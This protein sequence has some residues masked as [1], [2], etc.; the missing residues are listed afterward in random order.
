MRA[1]RPDRA[2][3]ALVAV[4][5]L[6]AGLAVAAPDGAIV[7]GDS[8]KLTRFE[9]AT[10]RESVTP[11]SARST[12]ALGFGG[13][14]VT[15]VEVVKRSTSAPDRYTVKLIRSGAPERALPPFS[16]SKGH[17]SGR[18]QPSP[19]ASLFAVHT[20]ESAG[21][22]EPYIDNVY[23]FDAQSRVK[24]RV[25]GFSDPVWAGSDRLVAVADDGLYA[26]P[27]A[28][29]RSAARIG[30]RRASPRRPALSPDG[31][32]IAF[33][34][35]DAVWR[36]GIDGSGLQRLTLPR[37]GQ[38]WPTWSPDGSRLVVVRREC[39]PVGGASPNP[40]LVIVSGSKADQDIERLPLVM[41]Q[42]NV[43]LRS[44]G[45]LYWTP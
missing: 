26:V 18:V 43:P 25:A 2:A 5:A 6:C 10:R 29:A 12:E 42:G 20:R 36:I 35:G 8:F 27:L 24:L 7:F 31:R 38:T 14:V 32:S 40:E 1:T 45:P 30:P 23:V 44:C 16:I 17:V 34:E 15:D 39:P 22:G 41:R 11:L 33:V 9:L 21:L 4:L 19:D 3:R 13:G 28:S 37:R